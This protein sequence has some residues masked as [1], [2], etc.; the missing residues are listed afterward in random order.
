MKKINFLIYFSFIFSQAEFQIRTIPNSVFMLSNHN[1]FTA[2]NENDKSK[3]TFNFDFIH[4]PANINYAN[5][6][7]KNYTLSILN[8]GELK[9]QI[10]NNI[11]KRFNAY[12][13]DVQY[14]FKKEIVEKFIF[15][16]SMGIAY[17]QIDYFNSSAILSNY[18]FFT[19]LNEKHTHI[20]LSI[21]N[22]G[23]ITN[24]YTNI[25]Q[26]LPTQIQLGIIKHINT[27]NIILGYDIIY[28]Y[29]IEEIENI[30]CIQFPIFESIKINISSSNFRKDLLTGNWRRDWLYGLAG[31]I[32][33]ESDKLVSNIGISNLGDSGFVYGISIDYKVH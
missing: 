19:K 18:K 32:K 6:Q 30:V 2:I 9:E 12:E 17:S 24:S 13:I 10:D 8:Y 22:L 31:G 21:N 20:A 14:H 29:N 1:G 15:D 23:I 4:Y 27:K 26:D 3:N 16:A 5:F 33:I 11:T 25:H 7:F 28:H